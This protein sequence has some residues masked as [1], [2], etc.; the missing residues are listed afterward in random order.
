M[1]EGYPSPLAANPRARRATS[2]LSYLA[3]LRV[4]F[5]WPTGHPVA[6]GLL[7][8]LFTLTCPDLVSPLTRTASPGRKLQ[9]VCFCGTFPEVTLAGRYPAPCPVE[10]GL[11]S[12][13]GEIRHPR[14][15]DLLALFHLISRP[16]DGQKPPESVFE[17]RPSSQVLLLDRHHQSIQGFCDYVNQIRATPAAWPVSWNTLLSEINRGRRFGTLRSLEVC[18]GGKPQQPGDK[19]S[20]KRLDPFV[21]HPDIIVEPH[22]FHS[23]TR[24]GSR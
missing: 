12:S 15:P 4:G 1:D 20:W 11:S 10:P 16:S 23:Y 8:H 22:A 14:L 7:H 13:A 6:G 2:S 9:A 17:S 5:A 3:L 24:F 19:H 18:P 21:E